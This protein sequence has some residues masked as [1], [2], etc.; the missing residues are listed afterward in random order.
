M[1]TVKSIISIAGQTVPQIIPVVQ[2][3]TGRSILF[4][5]AD[6]TIPTGATATYYIQ[7]PSGEAVYNSAT[8]EANTVLV[9]L[10]AQSIIEQGDNYGQVRVEKDDEVVTSFDFILLVKP[11]RGI[12]ATQSTTEMN[13]FDKAVEQAEEAIDEAKDAALEEIAEASENIAEEFDASNSYLAGE[14]TIYQG[15]LYKF[16]AAHT[17]A[18]TGSDAVEVTV[19]DELTSLN[20]DNNKLNGIVSNTLLVSDQTL[21]DGKYYTNS[22]NAVGGEATQTSNSNGKYG[23]FDIS[24]ASGCY[25][26]VETSSI[27]VANSV[28]SLICD[29][30]NVIL[31]KIVTSQWL[32]LS[33]GV[34]KGRLEIPLSAKYLHFSVYK[35][36]SSIKLSQKHINISSIGRTMYVSSNGSDDS[37]G[38]TP[39]TAKSTI[40]R[41]IS[42]GARNI[43]VLGGI[44]YQ[45]ID[46]KGIDGDIRISAAEKDKL[47]VF[48]APDSL[49]TDSE[50]AVSG[51]TKVYSA[52]CTKTFD[53]KI[54][55]IFQDGI[56][57]A[58]TEIAIADKHPLSRG[59]QYRCEDT[60]IIKCSSTNTNDAIAEIETADDYKWY[61]D[62]TEQ[63]IYFSRPENVTAN[64]PIMTSFETPLFTNISRSLFLHLDGLKVKYM[65]YNL[66]GLIGAD[67][68]NCECHNAMSS[69][70]FK[71]DGT[72]NA[73]F[74][75][76]ESDRIFYSATGGDGFNGH[77]VTTGD[78]FAHQTSCML[79]DCWGHD[80][81]DD[82][83]SDHERCEISIYGGLFEN[84]GG[85]GVTPALGSHC[86]CYNV[87]SR[88]NAQA[89]FFYTGNPNEYEGGTGGQIAC[90]NCVSVGNGEG[91]GFRLNGSE[92]QG[93]YVNCVCINRDTAFFGDGSGTKSYATLINCST[94]NCTTQKNT[95]YEIKNGVPV[96]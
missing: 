80:C 3:D 18:W 77:S 87:V 51:T 48:Y 91:R 70:G 27:T 53:N 30:N 17:G 72:A 42:D 66:V 76:C 58:D 65:Y 35:G 5:L 52:P 57:D 71:W 92:V 59:R 61:L 64:Y 9:N 45:N 86:T 55:W 67:V 82:G 44:F 50:T 78:A 81:C 11:F 10:T 63:I 43:L 24:Y 12:N 41:A 96:V 73:K 94:V 85:S 95:A 83:Y 39:E 15:K 68:S 90:F 47:P 19:G 93:L 25:I 74:Y 16:T 84:N 37:D 33:D 56:P 29:S 89:D 62:T 23:I 26:E 88:Y 46:V 28:V 13:I 2:G 60:K 14:Y 49:I 8:I 32:T 22:S 34:Y 38:K 75:K 4:T 31:A 69:G 20:D 21:T 40:S 36:S 6:F 54:V 7:K 1:I 79:F